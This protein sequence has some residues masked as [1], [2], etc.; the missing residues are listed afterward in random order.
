MAVDELVQRGVGR[1]AVRRVA[2]LKDVLGGVLRVHVENMGGPLLDCPHPR[3]WR[4]FARLGL[5]EE[6]D[7]RRDALAPADM[8]ARAMLHMAQRFVSLVVL[9]LFRLIDKDEG[10]GVDG[11][12][13]DR[14]CVMELAQR[15]RRRDLGFEDLGPVVDLDENKEVGH[16]FLLRSGPAMGP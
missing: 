10:F 3:A 6:V 4:E 15:R 12:A 2:E 11:D 16:C 9:V 14:Q 8:D 1:R 5:V 7:R 13:K